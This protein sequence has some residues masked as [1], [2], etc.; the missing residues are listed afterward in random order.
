MKITRALLLATM[1]LA[2]GVA[3]A[4][5]PTPVS[6]AVRDELMAQF[7]MSMRKFIALADAMPADRF[8]WK[9][10]KDAMPVGLVYAHVAHYNYYY[11][12]SNMGIA[13]PAGVKLDTLENLR[14]KAQIVA[15]LRNSADHVRRSVGAMSAEQLERP[16]RLYGRDVQHWS[17]LVQLVAHMNEHLGQSIAYA[18]SNGVVPPWSR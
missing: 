1:V 16:T 7:N 10:E 12:S 2:P 9:P 13:A 8:E 18:R 11:T 3:P 5:G 6:S 17:V 4:Q 14:D 15:L